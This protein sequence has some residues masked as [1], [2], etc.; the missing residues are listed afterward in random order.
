MNLCGCEKNNNI[1]QIFNKNEIKNQYLEDLLSIEKSI[2]N[3]KGQGNIKE[4]YEFGKKLGEGY[5][6]EVYLG[7]N[8]ITNEKVAIKILKKKK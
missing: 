6:G 5:Y 1:D 3:G 8:K 7:K 2:S 4:K